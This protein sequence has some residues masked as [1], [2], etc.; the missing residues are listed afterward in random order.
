MQKR[1][2]ELNPEQPLHRL[3]LAQYLIKNGQKTEARAEL[4]RLAALGSAFAKQQE[5]EKLLSSL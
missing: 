2:V 3:H 1:A 4:Q 5:V